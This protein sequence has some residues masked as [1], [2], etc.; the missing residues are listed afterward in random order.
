MLFRFKRDD[1]QFVERALNPTDRS[2]TI[3]KL[4]RVRCLDTVLTLFL[5]MFLISYPGRNSNWSW[6]FLILIILLFTHALR[7][8]IQIKLF[9]LFDR[10]HP[11]VRAHCAVNLG[12]EESR[13][14]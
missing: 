6:G 12:D 2:S 14:E 4:E 5:V 8:D 10:L 13:Q 11:E 3:P 9:K 7:T 1:E